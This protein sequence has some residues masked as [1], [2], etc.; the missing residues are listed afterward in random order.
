VAT[1][2]DSQKSLRK[3]AHLD[4]CAAEI[5]VCP[6]LYLHVRLFRSR[7]RE[8][9]LSIRQHHSEMLL[10]GDCARTKAHEM[11]HFSKQQKRNA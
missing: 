3:S 4:W 11:R 10:S 1:V 2:S 6:R 7:R 8:A 9:R 5:K